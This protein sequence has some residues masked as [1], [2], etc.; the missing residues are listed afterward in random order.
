MIF[1]D[2]SGFAG[3]IGASITYGPSGRKTSQPK[4]PSGGSLH[5]LVW[6][7]MNLQMKKQKVQRFLV[8]GW[9]CYSGTP[10]NQRAVGEAVGAG[11]NLRS[12]KA[13]GVGAEQEDTPVVRR[14][15]EAIV[16]DPDMRTMRIA[17][18][19]FLFKIKAAE[20]DRC[21][22][23][24]G[25]QIPRHILMQCPRY[26]VP[27][28]KLW[29]Q[30]WGIGINEMDYDKIVS[31]HPLGGQLYAPDRSPPA[32]PTRWD[33]GQRRRRRTEGLAAIDLGGCGRRWVLVNEDRRCCGT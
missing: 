33:R 7:A 19:H 17:L 21:N 13:L 12:D 3:H 10:A 6:T 24:E 28:T 1:T 23:D 31:Y 11:D 5:T 30:L 20:T 27:R 18:R 26:V 25:S 14:A 2:G 16:Y 32:V 22:C 8:R 29:E 9:D 15:L 4:S